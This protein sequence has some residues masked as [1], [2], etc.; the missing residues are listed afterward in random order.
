[1]EWQAYYEL[2]P[3]GEQA[4]FWR[5]AMIA[6]VLANIHRNRKKQRQPFTIADFLPSD[7]RDTRP[8]PATL[9]AKLDAAMAA[10]GGRK[11]TAPGKAKGKS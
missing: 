7:A 8:D 6:S 2:E 10:F 5:S 4:A 9:R 3:F 1:M 11:T